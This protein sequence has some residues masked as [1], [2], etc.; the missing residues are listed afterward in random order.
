V[1]SFECEYGCC[2]GVTPVMISS[3]VPHPAS[4][5]IVWSWFELLWQWTSAVTT[6]C[7]CIH[8]DPVIRL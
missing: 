7:V 8:S 1:E 6:C 2:A 4:S 3:I 5:M